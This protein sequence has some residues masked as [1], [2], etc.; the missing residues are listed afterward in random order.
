MIMILIL[1]PNG[2]IVQ[3]FWGR[4][5]VSL[6]EKERSVELTTKC[7]TLR[8]ETLKA[9]GIPI[10]KDILDKKITNIKETPTVNL[11]RL[12]EIFMRCH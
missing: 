12:N 4:S 2:I 7:F 9:E 5:I 11:E 6:T 1:T 10:E 3:N 8:Y